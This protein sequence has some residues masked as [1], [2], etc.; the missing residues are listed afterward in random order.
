M[1]ICYYHHDGR[2]L[3]FN[4]L[5]M[6]DFKDLESGVANLISKGTCGKNMKFWLC[7]I[8]DYIKCTRLSGLSPERLREHYTLPDLYQNILS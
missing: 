7:G 5:S 6:K 8:C 1:Q 2:I 3:L 4:I